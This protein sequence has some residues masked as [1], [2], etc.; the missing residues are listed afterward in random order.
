MLA[1]S[2]RRW[3]FAQLLVAAGLIYWLTSNWHW[4]IWAAV[5]V[6][7][8]LSLAIAILVVTLTALWSRD[9]RE[10]SHLW[11]RSLLGEIHASAVT[12]ALRQPWANQASVV[13][14]PL[15]DQGRTPV[16]LVHGYFCNH[17]VWRDMATALRAHGHAV[18]AIDLE[19]LVTSIDN[20]APHIEAAVQALLQHTG[21]PRVALIG[22]SMGGL[23]IR[24]WMRAYGTKH[25]AQVITLGTPHVGTQLAEGMRDINVQQMRWQSAWLADLAASE[26]AATR[27]LIR[28]AL[29]PQDSIVYP[30]RAQVLPGITATVFEGVGHLQMCIHPAVIHWVIHQLEG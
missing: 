14:L 5:A 30:Q 12:Y 15:A 29:T 21:A 19:P 3:L 9:W 1:Q 28:M 6:Y 16:V 2:L 27:A 13:V 7:V 20:Y 26:T 23:A 22:H 11:W 18:I 25:V 10:P 17:G 24:A 4:P 8:L